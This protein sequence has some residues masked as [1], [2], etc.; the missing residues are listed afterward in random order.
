MGSWG[1]YSAATLHS[2]K[3]LRLRRRTLQSFFRNGKD[4]K[5]SEQSCD[6]F[7]SV[8]RATYLRHTARIGHDCIKLAKH[9]RGDIE[10][11]FS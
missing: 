2:Q 3:I 9:L 11:G 4:V 8:C 7:D 6:G 1:R 5:E 10:R